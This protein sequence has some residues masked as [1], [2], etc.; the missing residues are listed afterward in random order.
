MYFAGRGRKKLL[1]KAAKG[2]ERISHRIIQVCNARHF[3]KMWFVRFPGGGTISRQ[4][5]ECV[6]RYLF[7]LFHSH[8]LVRSFSNSRFWLKESDFGL[9]KWCQACFWKK[10]PPKPGSSSKASFLDGWWQES[11]TKRAGQ[12]TLNPRSTWNFSLFKVRLRKF[13]ESDAWF[14]CTSSKH[15]KGKKCSHQSPNPKFSW[16]SAFLTA[17]VLES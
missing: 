2:N 16:T 15:L 8:F 5:L 10:L 11:Y 4:H 3:Q 17:F 7:V 6:E 12:Q 9:N 1:Q 13:M 14:E